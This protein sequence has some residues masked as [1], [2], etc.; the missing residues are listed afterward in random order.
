LPRC[1]WNLRSRGRLG[2]NDCDTGDRSKRGRQ[3][4][5]VHLF[6]L[7]I[8]GD[9][10]R[11][12]PQLPASSTKNPPELT[13][14]LPTYAGVLLLSFRESVGGSI[15]A[16]RTGKRRRRNNLGQD[17]RPNLSAQGHQCTLIT[18]EI[19]NVWAI[20]VLSRDCENADYQG[21]VF[22]STAG[23]RTVTVLGR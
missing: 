7:E 22:R 19:R 23:R 8:L 13:R 16:T 1:G 11:S 2:R 5:C 15:S 9:G 3:G 4:I 20:I 12:A 17:L 10:A 21:A 14:F 18:R 6:L